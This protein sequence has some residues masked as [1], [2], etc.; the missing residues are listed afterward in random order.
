M[1]APT[2]MSTAIPPMSTDPNILTLTQLLSPTFPVGAFAY[3][4]GLEA[5]VQEGLVTDAISL[6][7]WL[8]DLL[9]CGGG[10]SDAVLLNVAFA[11]D[12]GDV[13]QIDASAR[14]F[15]ASAERRMETNLQGRA[16]CEALAAV[17]KIDLGSL[18]YPVAVGRAAQLLDLGV[19]MTTAL[20]LQAF[21]GNL[22]AAAM[23]LVPLGQVEGQKVQNALRPLCLEIAQDVTDATL[24]D[25]HGHAWMSDIASMRHET[26]YSRIFRT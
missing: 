25:L 17:W 2:R 7:N 15:C 6:E 22:T 4:H 10:R 1:D 19:Q 11:A 21:V 24:D 14:A 3:S 8:D 5:A 13:A 16:F 26:L 20:Y 9:R 18:T 23:R 12:Q